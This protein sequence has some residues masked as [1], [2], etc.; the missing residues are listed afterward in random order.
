MKQSLEKYVKIT[1]LSLSF[2]LTAFIVL[3]DTSI[4]SQKSIIFT[5]QAADFQT[6]CGSSYPLCN[7]SCNIGYYCKGTYNI[8]VCT[9]IPPTPT[10]K[11]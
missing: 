11:P 3:V 1:V 2:F 5:P 9:R 4:I 10:L 8:C 7:G 6:T